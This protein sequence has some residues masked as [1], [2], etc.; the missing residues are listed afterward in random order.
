MAISGGLIGMAVSHRGLQS[1]TGYYTTATVTAA[2]G[3]CQPDE[4]K[5]KLKIRYQ[6]LNS[7]IS[8]AKFFP[9]LPPITPQSSST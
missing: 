6:S 2:R 5:S 9:S 7:G 8:G 1:S 4:H 3:Y